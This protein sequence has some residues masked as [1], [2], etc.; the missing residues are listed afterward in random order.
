V[1]RLLLLG[2]ALLFC[3]C[4]SAPGEEAKA[5][6][7]PPP[8]HV[9]VGTVSLQ[10]MARLY[11]TS[12][13]MRARVRT[14]V[15]ARTR[16]VV[17]RLLVEA[18]D[19]VQVQQVLL[20]LENADQQIEVAAAQ[21]AFRDRESAWKKAESLHERL[22][23]SNDTLREARLAYHEA[24]HRLARAALALQRTTI[25]APFAGIVLTRATDA[26]AR[27]DDGTPLLE[28]ADVSQLEADVAVPERHV[29]ALRVGQTAR[30]EA[31]GHQFGAAIV[32]I[33]P[34][35]DPTSGTIK[36]TLRAEAGLDLRPGA[37]ARVAI[38]TAL[39]S[40]AL[41][42]PRSALVA[43]GGS[44]QLFRVRDGS[45]GEPTTVERLLVEP[46]FEDGPWVEVVGASLEVGQRVVVRGAAA[47][48]D[49]A[50]VTWEEGI[51]PLTSQG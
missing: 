26:G 40:T 49:E 34:A 13:R 24:K 41:V 20:Q 7:P 29:P 37:F 17:Q 16:G 21:D 6:E 38:V 23:L 43:E 33:S 22:A 27:V 48:A 36:V 32:R 4:P 51:A 2:F 5:K 47:L 3:G 11:R 9:G 19:Q 50:R 14:A 44:W 42:V 18:G 35:V 46:G 28:L 8:I 15:T 12:A 30:L 45:P 31:A 1:T 10:P 25:R 39:H